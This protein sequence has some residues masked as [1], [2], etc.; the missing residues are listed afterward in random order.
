M[1]AFDTKGLLI[2][3]IPRIRNKNVREMI[4]KFYDNNLLYCLMSI[5][6]YLERR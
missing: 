6:M 4:E 1:E 3:G 2:I 5:G